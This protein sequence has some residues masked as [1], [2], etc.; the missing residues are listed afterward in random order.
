M[1]RIAV[2]YATTEGHTLR[3]AEAIVEHLRAAGIQS[4]AVDADTPAAAD[5]RWTDVS[6]AVVAASLHA[7]RHQRAA[8]AFVRRHVLELNA[9]PSIFV[10]VSLSICSTRERDVQEARSIARR[11][12]IDLGWKVGRVEC[13]AGRLA[14][15][16][17][18]LLKR[19][20]MRRIAA[21]SG[22][23]TDV[24]RNHEMTDWQQV[25][26][27]AASLAAMVSAPPRGVRATA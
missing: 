8:E 22:G 4:E 12:P 9:R 11:F 6:A 2:F 21:Q 27:I 3:I 18:G 16:Q 5:Y 20:M 19:T 17:Y 10:S 26:S 24:S 1:A 25:R 14:Y 23:P 15:R 7:G 13:V